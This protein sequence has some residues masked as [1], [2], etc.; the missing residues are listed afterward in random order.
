MWPGQSEV[1]ER[2]LGRQDM[3]SSRGT[4]RNCPGTVNTNTHALPGVYIHQ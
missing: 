2:V 1:K 4:Y 3:L